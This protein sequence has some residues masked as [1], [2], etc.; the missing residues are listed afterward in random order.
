M[1]NI[2]LNLPDVWVLCIL[3]IHFNTNIV[4]LFWKKGIF[5]S[6]NLCYIFMLQID[7]TIYYFFRY[8]T[9]LNL[10][11]R[12]RSKSYLK[13]LKWT[14]QT[15]WGMSKIFKLNFRCNLY[16]CMRD[17]IFSYIFI[18]SITCFDSMICYICETSLFVSEHPEPYHIYCI[19]SSK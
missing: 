18:S 13:N 12:Y 8:S 7:W 16:S 10:F 9:E 4:I 2:F 15:L 3:I 14:D 19:L 5:L 11:S 6:H 17:L 1:L